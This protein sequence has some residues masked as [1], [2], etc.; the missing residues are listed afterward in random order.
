MNASASSG[1][2]FAALTAQASWMPVS[3]RFRQIGSPFTSPV[4]MP[5]A[6]VVSAIG[7][8]KASLLQRIF[9]SSALN[10]QL[11]PN[12]RNFSIVDARRVSPV[13]KKPLGAR[14]ATDER[15]CPERRARTRRRCRRHDVP[16]HIANGG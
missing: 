8:R 1:V 4:V 16:G 2:P 7:A 14:T 15:S 6:V 11:K 9:C 12:P 13:K 3:S 5:E 10:W